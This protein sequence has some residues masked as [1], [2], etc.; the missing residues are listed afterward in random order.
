MKTNL[1]KIVSLATL[2]I[3]VLSWETQHLLAMIT[4]TSL[5]A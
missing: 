1:L 4:K 3:S 2:I 5:R